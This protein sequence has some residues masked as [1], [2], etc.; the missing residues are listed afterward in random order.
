MSD[1]H[2]TTAVC[3]GGPLH[4]REITA[5]SSGFL[6]VDRA[7]GKAWKYQQDGG[8]FVVNTDHDDS[9]IYPQGATTGERSFD[10]DR[11]WQAGVN[12]A[13]DVI[14]VDAS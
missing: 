2:L 12:S 8:V 7:A 4:S 14:A 5:R 11:A 10:P 6:A 1:G 13:L 9:L 3:R